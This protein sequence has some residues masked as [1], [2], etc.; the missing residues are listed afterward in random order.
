MVEQ[1]CNSGELDMSTWWELVRKGTS[2]WL[3]LGADGT[4]CLVRGTG[5]VLWG[6]WHRIGAEVRFT[7]PSGEFYMG[8]VGAPVEGISKGVVG[9]GPGRI[10]GRFTARALGPPPPLPSLSP[11]SVPLAPPPLPSLP[12]S[13]QYVPDFVSPEDEAILISHI[14]RAEPWRWSGGGGRRTVS[15]RL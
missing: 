12:A 1:G 5:D 9:R 2:E 7:L 4:G 8:R 3:N 10:T 14:R 15:V 13:V 6:K 11:H